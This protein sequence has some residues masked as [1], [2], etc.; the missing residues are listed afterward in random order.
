M[1]K[2]LLNKTLNY[3][4][5][6]ALVILMSIGPAFYFI[7][8]ILFEDD[9]DEDLQVL[10]INFNRFTVN[11]LSTDDIVTWNAISKDVKIENFNGIKKDTL[12]D[13][14]FYDSLNR[15]NEPFRV[16][17]SPIKIDNQ[18][19]T[20]SAR[21]NMVGKE[22]L[23]LSTVSLFISL[24]LLLIAGFFII[25]KIISKTI[26][27]PFY[28]ALDRIER[29]EID[30]NTTIELAESSTEEFERLNAAIQNLI[31]KNTLIYKSQKEFIENAA[32]ELQTPIAIFKGKLD[33]LLQRSD[34][35]KEQFEI[36][37]NLNTTTA[38]LTR[39]NKNLL[40]LSKIESNQYHIP[41]HVE[42]NDIIIN[43]IDFFKEQAI[44]KNITITT[45]LQPN[46]D[47]NANA[48]LTEIMIKN[49]FLNAVNHNVENG[50]ITV[51]LKEKSLVFSNT[52]ISNQLNADKLFERFSKID[53]SSKGN[54]LGLSIIKKIIDINSWSITYRFEN[55]LH[56]FEIHF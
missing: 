13:L 9:A 25:T 51:T 17:Q 52:G 55:N 35:T 45:N 14:T 46:I 38:K 27:H 41:E 1:T 16:L 48:F 8:N 37:D 50:K 31:E 33:L 10:K 5:I 56:V 36:L 19:Y 15:E 20:F 2:K 21:M 32:H 42:L 54:G 43:Q 22:N 44:A 39:L 53:P 49:L 30:K 3:Y 6:Y 26:W 12:F 7:S 18:W 34:L 29:F 4:F 24:L 40:L 23:V 11:K 28:V 47:V